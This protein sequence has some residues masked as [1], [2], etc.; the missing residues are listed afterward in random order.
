MSKYGMIQ[1]KLELFRQN[2]YNIENKDSLYHFREDC[3]FDKKISADSINNYDYIILDKDQDE[4]VIKKAIIK[5]AY[6]NI[7]VGSQK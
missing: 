4:T 3:W 7:Y 1:F 6:Q 2:I 5:G